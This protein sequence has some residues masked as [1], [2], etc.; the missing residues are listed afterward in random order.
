M[1]TLRLVIL[2]T[3]LGLTLSACSREDEAG[4]AP[5]GTE[6]GT[7]ESTAGSTD[8]AAASSPS[9]REATGAE[10]PEAAAGGDSD[11]GGASTPSQQEA[12]QPPGN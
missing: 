11:P 9:Q 8:P 6:A 5:A 2:A 4:R 7:E 1:N 12:T 10:T 3:A